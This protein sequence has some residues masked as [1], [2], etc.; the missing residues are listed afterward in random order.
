MTEDERAAWLLVGE[1]K[2]FLTLEAKPAHFARPRSGRADPAET[3][4]LHLDALPIS[5]GSTRSSSPPRPTRWYPAPAL[6]HSDQE[7]PVHALAFGRRCKSGL[8]LAVR[9]RVRRGNCD[10]RCVEA[11]PMVCWR[12]SRGAFFGTASE[13]HRARV[14]VLVAVPVHLPARVHTLFRYR[15]ARVIADAERGELDSLIDGDRKR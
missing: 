1:K 2:V 5:S 13:D 4:A 12:V 9:S 8:A 10:N 7:K 11:R 15:T 3:S 6:I 14:A